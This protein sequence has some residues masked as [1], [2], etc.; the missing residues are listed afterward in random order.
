MATDLSVSDR[1][2]PPFALISGK[3]LGQDWEER[4]KNGPL[5]PFRRPGVP[6][7]DTASR[8]YDGF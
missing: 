6:G 2:Y 1:Q 3:G 7:A 4:G 5:A 8:P